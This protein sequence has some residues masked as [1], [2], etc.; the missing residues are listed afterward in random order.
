MARKLVDRALQI[1][2]EVQEDTA[3]RP[4]GANPLVHCGLWRAAPLATN[5][6]RSEEVGDPKTQTPS[7]L[8]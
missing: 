5:S 6:F 2:P 7:L 1:P 4:A 3:L 8:S